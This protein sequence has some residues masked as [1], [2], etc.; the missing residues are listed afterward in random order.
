MKSFDIKNGRSPNELPIFGSITL[1]NADW[2]YKYTCGL[3]EYE[4]DGNPVDFDVNFI[5]VTE[6][7]VKKVSKALNDLKKLNEIGIESFMR[8]FNPHCITPPS[9]SK[10]IIQF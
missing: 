1:D 2:E 4:F 8:D 3:R 9:K 5:E 10:K 6:E 7:N